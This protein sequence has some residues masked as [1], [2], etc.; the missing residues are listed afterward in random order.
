LI[1]PVVALRE[2]LAW[3]ERLPLFGKGV[4]VTRPRHQ[5]G[6]LVRRLEL[7][8]A[9]PYL[10]PTVEIREPADWGPVDRA[11][12]E[13]SRYDWL[14]FTSSN[15]VHSFVGRLR[16]RGRDLRALG[17][18]RLAV[19][20]PGTA[21]AL[22]SY[23][24]EPDLMPAS[25][26]SE[27][28]AAALQERAAGERLLLARADRG[29]DLLRQELSRVATVDQ[30]TVYSQVDTAVADREAHHALCTGQVEYVTVTSSNIARGLARLVDE[31]VHERIRSGAIKVV[32]ISPVT[33]AELHAI[34]WPVAAEAA[35][36]TVAGVVEALAGLA[37]RE[38]ESR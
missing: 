15:G 6:E 19:I 31:T 10:L 35:E 5:A 13:L 2:R 11:I 14:V 20:G 29:R 36:A 22:R 8:G 7:L 25:Y 37:V 3:F 21:D 12:A 1:G 30:V 18:L 28:L 26:Q 23:H 32:G 16:T 4:L 9:I 27:G 38:R 33:S 17:P 24:L 34:G